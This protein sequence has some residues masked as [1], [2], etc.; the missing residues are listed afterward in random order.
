[1]F[2]YSHYGL[3]LL[4]CFLHE[5]CSQ[6]KFYLKQSMETFYIP[7]AKFFVILCCLQCCNSSRK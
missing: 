3:I 2:N 5:L 7:H 6:L 1:M 4:F